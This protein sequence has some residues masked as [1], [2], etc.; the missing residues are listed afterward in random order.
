MSLMQPFSFVPILTVTS[1]TVFYNYISDSS[2]VSKATPNGVNYAG[3]I[4]EDSNTQDSISGLPMS[5]IGPGRPRKKGQRGR[6]PIYEQTPAC[7][8]HKLREVA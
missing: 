8:R 6:P 5:Y 7:K 4:S 2:N 3:S 1:L